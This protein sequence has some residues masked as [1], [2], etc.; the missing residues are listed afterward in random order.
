[1]VS[2]NDR[3]ALIKELNGFYQKLQQLQ[4]LR[5]A[6][7]NAKASSLDVE[8]CEA[9]RRELLRESGKFQPIVTKLTERRS[10]VAFGQEFALWPEALRGQRS[11]TRAMALSMLID[12][13]IE[14]IGR[15]E[16]EPELEKLFKATPSLES[17]KA[18]IAHG[19]QSACLRKLCDFLEA[20]GVEPVA[21]EWSASEGRLTEPQVDKYLHEADC[22]IILATYGHIID[23]K[24]REKHPRLNVVDELGRCRKVF[25]DRTILLLERDV[26]LPSNVSGIVYERFTKQ[27]MEKAFIKVARELRAFGLIQAIKPGG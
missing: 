1:M 24:T 2:V 15:L 27:N 14:A 3:D 18:F 11:V 10:A 4:N 9:L 17:P 12:A 21:A 20:L 7:D 8:K 16:A 25:P 19:G 6:E 23:A 26:E 13:V 5:E 22:G